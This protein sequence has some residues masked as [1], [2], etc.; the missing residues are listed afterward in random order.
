MNIALKYFIIKKFTDIAIQT[1][2]FKLIFHVLYMFLQLIN[3]FSK[4]LINK[5]ITRKPQF[6]LGYFE[7]AM[8]TNIN[9]I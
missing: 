6:V 3:L 4:Q 5:F 8:H 7:F 1:I 9:I 2:T